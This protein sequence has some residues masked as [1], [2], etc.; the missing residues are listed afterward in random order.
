[1]YKTLRIQWQIRYN[2]LSWGHIVAGIGIHKLIAELVYAEEKP[3]ERE[4]LM[5]RGMEGRQYLRS[6]MRAE[7]LSH[8]M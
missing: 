2:P 5:Y 3:K 7:S 1:M 4:Q 6:D 8:E